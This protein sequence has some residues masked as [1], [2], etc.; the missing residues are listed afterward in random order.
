MKFLLK[1]S[2]LYLAGLVFILT[3]ADLYYIFLT[4]RLNVGTLLIMLPLD[5]FILLSFKK[6]LFNNDK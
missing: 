3:L 2:Y 5:I 1:L 6:I 4:P